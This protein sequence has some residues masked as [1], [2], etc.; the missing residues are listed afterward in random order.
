MQTSSRQEATG[1][2]DLTKLTCG[3][4][5]LR[6]P[7]LAP[8]ACVTNAPQPLAAAR[9]TA[10]SIESSA[11]R[12]DPYGVAPSSPSSAIDPECLQAIGLSNAFQ[13]NLRQ[14]HRLD[15]SYL[16][17]ASSYLYPL[18]NTVPLD[19]LEESKS[20]AAPQ[21]I[22]TFPLLRAIDVLIANRLGTCVPSSPSSRSSLQSSLGNG[23]RDFMTTR[24]YSKESVSAHDKEPTFTINPSTSRNKNNRTNGN[25]N[26]DDKDADT[27]DGHHDIQAKSGVSTPTDS[28]G[29]VQHLQQRVKSLLAT[30]EK[31]RIA[32][33]NERTQ[34]L[35]ALRKY[36]LWYAQLLRQV[37]DLQ[38]IANQ[39]E[40]HSTPPS[41]GGG[42]R[43]CK[44]VATSST[45]TKSSPSQPHSTAKIS[46][47][48]RDD[49]GSSLPQAKAKNKGCYP[50]H[51]LH[52]TTTNSSTTAC[53]AP[54]RRG[55]G[56]GDN[57]VVRG[58]ASLMS[59]GGASFAELMKPNLISSDINLDTTDKSTNCF[60][61]NTEMELFNCS[62]D[63]GRDH[64]STCPT[65]PQENDG[66]SSAKRKRK[67]HRR[68]KHAA[69]SPDLTTAQE[70]KDRNPHVIASSTVLL[71]LAASKKTT[72][73]TPPNLP[74]LCSHGRATKHNRKNEKW[75]WSSNPTKDVAK[76]IEMRE[77]S[78]WRAE[79]APKEPVG[80]GVDK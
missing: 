56:E 39:K 23:Q 27:E 16:N 62:R 73:S 3:E 35:T 64:D 18:S 67:K 49:I 66:T 60:G 80:K 22:P 1:T 9:I 8:L 53:T 58:L 76:S 25:D 50:S 2:E 13:S 59:L 14:I 6:S 55:D 72:V 40:K 78:T 7:T 24:C 46:T 57:R 36:K 33:T 68:A 51:S 45:A 20:R 69:T 32:H 26:D 19:T 77:R 21:S 43:N 42:H 28:Q 54:L 38:N 79:K 31:K 10:T 47:D 75:G 74:P 34:L 37:N 11:S 61:D 15:E 41:A 63:S 17:V 52:S 29:Q 5:L 71:P 70:N 30:L 44:N 4:L 65:Q 48:I 12:P